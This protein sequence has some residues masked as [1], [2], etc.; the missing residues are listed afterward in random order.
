MS[1]AK[2]IMATDPAERQWYEDQAVINIHAQRN[3]MGN[4]H[5]VVI[6]A[7]GYSPSVMPAASWD[8]MAQAPE[9]T[10]QLER[11][12]ARVLDGRVYFTARDNARPYK[13]AR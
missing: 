6:E 7:E 13:P 1:I 5:I 12:G 4:S 8:V 11:I 10:Q 2:A 3:L 9:I